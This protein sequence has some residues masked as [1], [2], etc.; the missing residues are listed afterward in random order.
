MKTN[1]T[2]K[3]EAIASDRID[4]SWSAVSGSAGYEIYRAQASDLLQMRD[5]NLAAVVKGTQYADRD[6]KPGVRYRY[7]VAPIRNDRRRAGA[8]HAISCA[9]KYSGL[10]LKRKGSKLTVFG[11]TF[12]ITWDMAQG[13]EVSEVRQYDGNAWV[14]INARLP[15]TVPNLVLTDAK[16]VEHALCGRKAAPFNLEKETREE[17]SFST[18]V[19]AC[20]I[21]IGMKYTVFREGVL[22]C[23]LTMPRGKVRND[24]TQGVDSE[25][26]KRLL[27]HLSFRMGLYLDKQIIKG[28]FAWGYFQR[29]FPPFIHVWK[30]STDKVVD[31]KH[32]LPIALVDF[33][34]NKECS[35]TNHL[36]FFIE[37]SPPDGAASYFGN[38]SRGGVKFEWSFKGRALRNLYFLPWDMGFLRMRWGMCLGASRKSCFGNVSSP[39]QNNLIG[40]RI[41]H[42][43][44]SQGVTGKMRN[45]WP[46][47]IPPVNLIK[48]PWEG[49]PSAKA[50]EKAGEMGANVIILHQDWM[51]SGGSNCEPPADYIP[52]DAAELKRFVDQCHAQG[53]RVGLY[54]RGVE[55]YAL[56]QPYFEKFLKRDFDGLYVDWSSPY[57]IGFQGCNELHFSAFNYFLFTRALRKRVGDGGF[58]IAHSGTAPTMI[59]LAVFDAYLPGEYCIQRD[60]FLN[61]VDEAV[62]H[63]FASCVGTNPIG[64]PA[65]TNKKAAAFYAGLGLYPHVNF[66]PA[67]Q[68]PLKHH[69]EGLWKIWRSIPIENAYVHNNLTENFKAVTTSNNNFYS[70]IYKVNRNLALLV[71]ANLGN[72]GNAILKINM[73]GL[74]LAGAYEVAEITVGDEGGIKIKN[75]GIVSDGVVVTGTCRPCEYRGY[76][77]TRINKK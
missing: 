21:E 37:D 39:R 22:F 74:G 60:N 45:E 35:F 49:L 59:A 33:G 42:Y 9:T 32:L 16:G 20:G 13:G 72:K 61:S 68:G 67:R 76:R 43:G 75:K 18:R 6:L 73:S 14:R 46:F 51:R 65:F 53:I 31:R 44:G 5:A 47:N 34:L 23:E 25:Q 50:I 10:C 12:E 69:L 63:G 52:R 30:K 62:Y 64:S 54:M 38:N 17:I 29:G 77:L 4:I 26:N 66:G 19:S 70:T 2:I 40:A 11:D 27:D 48:K 24:R 8:L 28:K 36:E 15:A 1:K 58:L 41:F 3:A 57:C 55:K 56:Y 7:L 71:S